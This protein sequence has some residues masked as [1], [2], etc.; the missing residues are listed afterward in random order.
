MRWRWIHVPRAL[1]WMCN[2]FQEAQQI[3]LDEPWLDLGGEG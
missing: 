1:L 2:W 3:E